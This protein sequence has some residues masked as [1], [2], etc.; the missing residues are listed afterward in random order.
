M[1]VGEGIDALRVARGECDDVGD[2]NPPVNDA[3]EVRVSVGDCGTTVAVLFDA[4]LVKCERVADRVPAV[5]SVSVLVGE[6][7]GDR[8]SVGSDAL[9]VR[10]G[11]GV[12]IALSVACSECDDETDARRPEGEDDLLIDV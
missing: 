2:T 9:A 11:L 4:V 5:G 3:V 6:A 7:L 8:D 12:G 1:G 10:V